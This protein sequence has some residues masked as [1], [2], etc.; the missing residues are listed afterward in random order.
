MTDKKKEYTMATN[1]LILGMNRLSASL[2]LAMKNG[3]DIH[4]IGFD[5]DISNTRAAL[6]AGALDQMV[7]TL[8]EGVIT[9]NVILYAL[10]V[11]KMVEVIDSIRQDLKPG[12][13]IVDLNPIGQDTFNQIR[14]VL[15]DPTR[16]I[17]WFA[18]L[19]PKYMADVESGPGSAQEDLFHN[20]H[21]YIAGDTDTHPEALKLGNDLAVLAGAKPLNTE[22]EELA[23]ILALG[24]DLPLLISA[25][26]TRLVTSEPGWN[27]ARKLAGF[28]FDHISRLLESTENQAMPESR[29]HVNRKNIQRLLSLMIEQLTDIYTALDEESPKEAGQVIHNAALAR[30]IWQ[31]QR[32]SMSWLEQ[33]QVR[34]EPLP[35]MGERL[36][37][38]RR[39]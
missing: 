25:V 4:R 7:E 2:G 23:G 12:C 13:Y 21:V 22:P 27:E 36:F 11:G 5:P 3:N 1:L 38:K 8:S 16:F 6:E 39:K 29:I 35:T 19:N 17:A 9:A 32:T 14:K 18:A 26:T 28:N 37:G 10:P 33:D 24:V 31:K 30:Q 15:P 20:S 34:S